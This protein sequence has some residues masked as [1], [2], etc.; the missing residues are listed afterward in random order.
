MKSRQRKTGRRSQ[1][2]VHYLYSKIKR[3]R[4]LL[5]MLSLRP[6]LVSSQHEQ[7]ETDRHA[8][9]MADRQQK[10][11]LKDQDFRPRHNLQRRRLSCLIFS[12]GIERWEWRGG[13][14]ERDGRGEEVGERGRGERGRERAL[15]LHYSKI[16]VMSLDIVFRTILIFLSMWRAKMGER[17][18]RRHTDTERARR[19]D[20]PPPQKNK[21]NNNN[22]KTERKKRGKQRYT[23]EQSKRSD[24]GE[25]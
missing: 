15:H 2:E 21:T 24:G 16:K 18:T 23:H 4:L 22:N 25:Q 19:I 14:G 6:L 10:M 5:L 20:Q 7:K 13:G 9:F 3:E 12:A 17:D 1:R 11:M 8:D